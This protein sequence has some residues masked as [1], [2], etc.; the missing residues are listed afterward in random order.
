[1]VVGVL[2]LD[3]RIHDSRSLKA[4]RGCIKQMVRKIKNTF[5]VSVAE[6]GSQ[7]KWQRT[8][9]GVAAVGNDRAVVNQKLDH[10]INFVESLGTAELI[11]HRIELINV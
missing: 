7:D 1:M 3:L 10:V 8:Q 9:I 2:Q 6:V 5:E 4:K 11:D